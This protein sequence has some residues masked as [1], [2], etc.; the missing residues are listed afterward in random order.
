ML[1]KKRVTL[2]KPQ[3]NMEISSAEPHSAAEAATRDLGVTGLKRWNIT[4]IIKASL[5]YQREK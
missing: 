5:H 4:K 1:W 3:E 2:T